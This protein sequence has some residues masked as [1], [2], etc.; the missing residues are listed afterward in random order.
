MD[1]DDLCFFC[2]GVSPGLAQTNVVDGL[3]RN[4]GSPLRGG[5]FVWATMN[6]HT[7]TDNVH[8]DLWEF[9]VD[10]AGPMDVTSTHSLG[11]EALIWGSGPISETV[12]N[13]GTTATILECVSCHDP[14][15]FGRTYRMLKPQPANSVLDEHGDNPDPL[16]DTYAYVTDILAFAQWNPT[17]DILSYTT[18]DYTEVDYAAPDVYDDTGNLVEVTGPPPVGNVTKYSQQI[19]RWCAACHERYHRTQQGHGPHAADVDSGDAIFTYGHKTGDDMSSATTT[20][21]C[22]YDGANCHGATAEGIDINRS[23]TCL[24]CHVSHG[25]SAT[26]GVYAASVPWPGEGVWN[27]IA[28]DYDPDTTYDGLPGTAIDVTAMDAWSN[29]DPFGSSNAIISGQYTAADW[30]TRSSLLRLNNR[31]VCQNAYCHPKGQGLG[32]EGFEQGQDAGIWDSGE[33]PDVCSGCHGEGGVGGCTGCHGAPPASGAHAAH[34][35]GDSALASYGGTENLSDQANYAFQCGT[36]HPLSLSRHQDGTLD[37]GIKDVELYDATAP[38]GTLKSLSPPSA[39][40]DPST[41]T[42]TDVY[43]HSRTNWDAPGPV[44]YPLSAPDGY[45]MLDVNGNLV[46]DPYT[47]TESKVYATVG[48]NDGPLGCNGCHR[49]FPQTGAPANPY[50]PLVGEDGFTDRGVGNSHEWVDSPWQYGNYHGWNMGFDPILC[51]SCHY[52]TVTDSQ[53]WTR[54]GYDRTYYDDVPIANKASHANGVKS[55]AFDPVNPVVMNTAWDLSATTYDLS[56]K[57]CS[58]VPC[59]LNQPNPQ[60]GLPYDYWNSPECDQCHRYGGANWPDVVGGPYPPE[61]AQGQ[62]AMSQGF[63]AMAAEPIHYEDTGQE[64]IDCHTGGH[65]AQ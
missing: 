20:T 35:G 17:S 60:W 31:G 38:A 32:M 48:W 10:Q 55:V 30:D 14:H 40:Y 49:S 18:A 63:S 16:E 19:A 50:M 6:T 57:V 42:C 45:V 39:T 41:G 11:A 47:V 21:S 5:G 61:A 15:Q 33:E 37:D 43:C 22:G 24:G 13:A 64:C 12:P 44:G 54:D 27:E 2:H 23:L 3:L 59:H 26:M 4:S 36:C 9:P 1:K 34:F 7:P 8:E 56:T 46:Y 65:A 29:G 58:N 25:T 52:D 62:S 28:G 51:R 53:T